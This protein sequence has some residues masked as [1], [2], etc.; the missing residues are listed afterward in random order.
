MRIRV[1]VAILVLSIFTAFP[2]RAEDDTVTAVLKSAGGKG[3][4][5]A[6]GL[7]APGSMYL[8]K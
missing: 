6:R 8:T 1:S 3:A 2:L 7:L 5:V 4:E